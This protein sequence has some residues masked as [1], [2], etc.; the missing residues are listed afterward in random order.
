PLGGMRVSTA[1]FAALCERVRGIADRHAGGRVLLSLEGGYEL[2]ALRECVR[3][4]I[5][6]LTKGEEPG[7]HRPA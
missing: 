1:G 7:I 3:A 2:G 4:C 5:G 6:V